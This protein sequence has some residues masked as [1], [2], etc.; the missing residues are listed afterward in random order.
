MDFFVKIL[1]W[2]FRSLQLQKRVNLQALQR[3][4]RLKRSQ[5]ILPCLRRHR[6]DDKRSQSQ[7]YGQTDGNEVQIVWRFRFWSKGKMSS[8]Q[9]LKDNLEPERSEI[10]A[11]KRNESRRR[12]FIQ[13]RIRTRLWFLPRWCLRQ[14]T[15]S[16]PP[17]FEERRKQPQDQYWNFSKRSH[18][19]I[20]K[21]DT[22]P[23]W[24]YGL[25]LRG[26]GY[27]GWKDTVDLEWRNAYQRWYG[28]LW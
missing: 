20:S 18:P 12:G 19:W 1:Y 4:G 14:A 22:A 7:R 15:W 28:Q 23:R 27:P 9:G 10:W 17:N 16:A 3:D 11:R 5:T 13:R 21:K 26:L 24:T 8:L 6:E 25:H 2:R